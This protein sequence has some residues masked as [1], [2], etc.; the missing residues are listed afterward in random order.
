MSA[1][2]AALRAATGVPDATTH[3]LGTGRAQSAHMQ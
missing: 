2:R 1:G 3:T